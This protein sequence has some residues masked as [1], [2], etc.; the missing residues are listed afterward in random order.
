M[1]LSFITFSHIKAP[2]RVL[3][4]SYKNTQGL[5]LFILYTYEKNL[6]GFYVSQ[7]LVHK[8]EREFSFSRALAN[9]QQ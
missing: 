2:D 8:I 9:Y 1:F 3:S 5:T 6:E 7:L 4:H